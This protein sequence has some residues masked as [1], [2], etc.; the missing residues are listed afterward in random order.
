MEKETSQFAQSSAPELVRFGPYELDRRKGEVRKHGVKLKISGQPIEILA[1]LLERP[2]EV[3]SRE[4]LRQR[5][6]QEGIFVDFERSL[7][8][9]VKKLRALLNDDSQ[10][11]RYIE[12]E[13]RKG[14]RFIGA[15][16]NGSALRP[17]EQ[18][19]SAGAALAMAAPS[20]RPPN[21]GE[22]PGLSL[23]TAI[24][25]RK[26][27][28][29]G[30]VAA[31]I[32]TAMAVGRM[33]MARPREGT[34]SSS[35]AANTNFRST[36]AV[37][38][39]KNLSSQN[40]ANWLSTAIRQMLSTELAGGNKV[41]IVP[42]EIVAR[43]KR[44][45]KLEDRDGYAR[46][47]LRMLHERLETDY[48]VAGSYVAVGDRK[49][50]Q[51]RVDLRLQEA[52]SGE[53]LTSIAVSGKQ[54]D[55]LE[56]VSR[57]GTEM[58]AKLGATIPPEGDVDWRTVL[59][60]HPAAAQFYAQ[61]LSRLRV[62][63]NYSACQLLQKSVVLEPDF[64]LAHAALA[65]AWSALGYDARALAS[66]QKALSL[67][68]G[69]PEDER[70]AVQGQYYELAHDWA[71][72]ISVYQHLLQDFANDLD[73]GLKLAHAQLSVGSIN[74]AA[75]T[76]SKLRSL[77][78]PEA[79]DPRIDL[80]EASLMAKNSDFKRQEALAE[81]AATKAERLGARLLLARARLVQGW[82]L[83]DQSQFPDAL[84]AYQTAE[85]ISRTA[86]D[87]DGRAT[88][89]N[90]IAIVLQK[91]GDLRGARF[92]QEQ[93]L[94][95]F[96]QVGDENGVGTVCINLGEV[97]RSQGDLAR[98]ED[99]YTEAL[100]LFRKLG[101]KDS[102]Y[103]A[104]NDLAAVL[105]ERAKFVDA[106]K[107]YKELL[108]LRKAAGDK[109]GVAYARTNLADVSRVQ[110]DLDEAVRL[111]QQALATF[112]EIGDRSTVASV[113]ASYARALM[114]RGDLDGAQQMLREALSINEQIGAK[115]DAALDRALLVQI[116]NSQGHLVSGDLAPA[117]DELRSEQRGSDEMEARVTEAEA[118]LRQG[119]TEMAG[120][121]LEKA[122]A[123]R[124][125]DWLSR[126]HLLMA[127]AELE[128]VRGNS[129]EARRLFQKMEND[130]RRV[131][132][133]ICQTKLRA[134]RPENRR[135]SASPVR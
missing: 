25:R 82:A 59:P 22:I 75:A 116:E 26:W 125:A 15:I 30:A 110:G 29:A 115:G 109:A 77:P 35:A 24:G 69:L 80:A 92:R 3:I 33:R 112:R 48:V 39:F 124:N 1:I 133:A 127:T 53:T 57:A 40:D 67:S 18:Q 91:T 102:E 34:A 101:R 126:F 94:A 72:A 9:A 23:K 42:E 5:L 135:A 51:V 98:A 56:L 118:L 132:C 95:D 88:A 104:M 90:D 46:D 27:I 108:E 64:A 117:I 63:E 43:A 123:I 21:E 32:L 96:R 83:D 84:Q 78:P 113:E 62:Y 103:V 97:Y 7:N 2:G 89:L 12:T 28:V 61:A 71:G 87:R 65:Q 120:S 85:E 54:A 13:P 81:R 37:L 50:G 93:A 86:D 14:Y 73:S 131:G 20:P 68:I 16:E 129:A 122:T 11:P 66:A 58:R 100:N 4:E 70:F 121:S 107:V 74:D 52:I 41:R 47:T 49:S 17:A 31:V 38:G 60:S 45:L 106:G 55:I 36:I 119:K 128:E 114:D 19:V 79:E 130:A 8:S 10:E 6:W 99:L 105:Y 44:E 76:I 134:M 111:Q